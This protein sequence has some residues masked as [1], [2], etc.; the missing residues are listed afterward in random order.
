[1]ME[2]MR[3]HTEAS[4][5]D[6]LLAVGYATDLGDE[7]K[8]EPLLGI[9]QAYKGLV[10]ELALISVPQTLTPLHLQILNNLSGISN[11]YA[12]MAT[13]LKD[14]LRG[15]AAFEL[16]ESLTEETSRVFTNIGQ[17]LSSSGILFNESEP[18]Y[19]WSSFIDTPQ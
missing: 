1:M 2:V 11:L 13:I 18:G 8:L 6:T 5:F 9:G 14:P 19:A 7:S 4:Y 15:L 16:Y 12:D 17:Q 10:G 3:T